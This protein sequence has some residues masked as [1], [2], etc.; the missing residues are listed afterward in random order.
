ME[1]RKIEVFSE[2]W[3]V[4]AAFASYLCDEIAKVKVFHLALSGGSTPKILFKILAEVYKDKIDWTKVH[5]YWGD[6]RCVAPDDEQS[7]FLMTFATMIE[8]VPIPVM[9]VHR[10]FGEDRPSTESVRYSKQ[11]MDYLPHQLGLPVFNMV[12]LG[13]GGDGHTASI[14]PHQM[15]LLE[16]EDNC[17]VATHPESGQQRITITGPV[18]NAAMQIHFLITGASKTAV[19][20][21]IFNESGNYKMYPASYIEGATWWL[22]KAAYP[23]AS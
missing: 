21:E 20:E 19:L 8:H 10:I 1:E 23:A 14:F 6:E 9:N 13:M 15:E 12:L 22:D 3:M 4:A 5:L 7:N 11:L 16:S 2:N 17:A 18:I